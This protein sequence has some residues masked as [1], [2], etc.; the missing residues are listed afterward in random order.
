VHPEAVLTTLDV[1]GSRRLD[2]AGP[3]RTGL[4]VRVA[5]PVGVVEFVTTH[6]AS[7][8]DDRPCDA[9]TCTPPCEESDTLN[10]CQ[11]REI[12]DLVEALRVDDDI[13]VLSGDLNAKPDEPTISAIRDAGYVDTHV[14]AGNDEC[15]PESGAQCTSGRID[16]SMEDLTDPQSLQTERIDYIWL[17]T[18]RDCRVIDPTGLFNG[19]PAEDGPG[20]LAFPSDHT[21]VQATLSCTTSASQVEAAGDAELPPPPTTTTE[22]GAGVDAAAEEAI[23]TAYETLFGGDV[24]DVEVKL[25]YLEDADL[26]RETFLASYEQQRE[27]ASRISVRIDSIEPIEPDRAAVTYSLLL[28]GDVVLDHLPGEAVRSG[29]D[30]LV[31]RQT[32]CDV[33]TQGQ[34]EI[35]EACQAP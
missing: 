31:T 23:T 12:V 11:A 1:L 30:W 29:D 6:L 19:E 34:P 4:V 8:S 26:L 13:V 16:D 27:I 21:A 15:D 24:T 18:G 35:P 5:A 22:P 3:L 28:D 25:A 20:G 32:Y 33:A 9:R 10:T 2:L 17:R 7:S 14:E